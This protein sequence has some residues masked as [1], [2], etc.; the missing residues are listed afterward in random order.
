MIVDISK[1]KIAT[2]LPVSLTNPVALEVMG[3]YALVNCTSCL[4]RLDDG[5]LQFRAPTKGA[6]SKSVH[7][8][9]MEWKEANYWPL[10]SAAH[11]WSRQK[12]TLVKVNAAQKV[13]VAQLH[14]KDA[15]TPPLKV[16]WNKG[17]ITIGFRASFDNP[18][19]M[20]TTI[21]DDVP[22]GVAFKISVHVTTAGS[23]SVSVLC[24]GRKSICPP[25]RLDSSWGDRVLQFH[26]GLYNQV[27]Y[28]A[29][30]AVD[31]ESV[32]IISELSTTHE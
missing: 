9:R 8:T 26:G 25:L 1:Y 17:K 4:L 15:N 27:D 14:V 16:F 5:S 32:C 10:S 3:D 23:V 20:N 30:T 7:R 21:L 22:L 11:H 12:M 28:S 6:S 13:V 18:E 2:P 19:I 31:D 29:N 24:E